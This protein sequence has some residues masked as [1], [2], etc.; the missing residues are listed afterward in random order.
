MTTSQL[1]PAGKLTLWALGLLVV[2][3]LVHGQDVATSGL[4]DRS[5]RLKASDYMR[6]YVT[7]ALAD[8]G[9]WSELFDATAH[10]AM[11]KARI[12]RRVEMQGLHP[13]YGPTAAWF[14]APLSRLPFLHSWALLAAASSAALLIGIWVLGGQTSALRSYRG[15]LVLAAA[16]SPALFETIRYGQLSAVTTAL[17]IVAILFDARGRPVL[18]GVALGLAFYKPN[19]VLPAAAVWLLGRQWAQLGGLCLGAIGHVAIGILVAGPDATVAWFEV[20]AKLARDP[21][22]VQGFP[23]DVHS[24]QG[25]WRLLGAHGLALRLLSLT[26]SVIAIGLASRC[27]RRDSDPEPRWAALILATVLVSP[28]LLTYDLLLLVPAAFL[29]AAAWIRSGDGGVVRWYLLG[30]LYFAPVGS[31]L[32]ARLTGVQLSTL[33][34][35]TVLGLLGWRSRDVP[36]SSSINPSIN[37]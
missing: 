30:A 8:Q 27:W 13:N 22:A 12:D 17:F 6:L 33:V 2:S 36:T 35:L 29:A 1:T 25:F 23:E 18:S 31:P 4:M 19:L 24:L 5:G 3:L 37:S 7:G 9:R 14:L 20:L 32:V 10:V 11:A 28:H 21:Q 26:C 34:M 15:L 16:A